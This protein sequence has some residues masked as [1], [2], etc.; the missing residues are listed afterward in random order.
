MEMPTPDQAIL[1]RKGRLVS[2]L[3]S[4][5]PDDAVISDEAETRAY[6]C[7]A[8]TAYKCPPLCAVLPSST[9]EVSAILRICHDE[10]VPVVPRG[11]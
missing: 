11:W 3:R 5:L 1:A 4:A 9:E 8:L 2:R 6:E 7:D 10:G